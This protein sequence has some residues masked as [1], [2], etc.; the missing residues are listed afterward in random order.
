M[1]PEDVLNE[2]LFFNR[3][4]TSPAVS[5][6]PSSSSSASNSA[7]RP[8]T[9]SDCPLLISAGVTK[10][11]HLRAALQQQHPPPLTQQLRAVLLALPPAWQSVASSA[12]AS[13]AWVQ[14]Q[15]SSSQQLLL[16]QAQ[17][18]Q[19]HTVSPHHQLLQAPAEAVTPLSPAQVIS[20]DPSRPWRG[21][22]HQ[23][24]Q[25]TTPLY[26]QGVLWG[27]QHLSLGVWGWGSQ[28]A[29]QLI[30]KQA[31]QRLRLIQAFATKHPLAPKG[32]TCRPR[33]LPLAQSGQSPAQALQ[34]MEARWV[35]SMHANTAGTARLHSEQPDSQ[36]AWMTP[37]HAGRLHWSQ[38]QQQRDEQQQQQHQQQQHQQRPRLP[39]EQAA[40]SDTIDVL[41]ACGSHPQQSN[42]QRVWELSNAAYFDRQHRILWWRILHGSLMCGAYRAYIGRATP[43]QASCPFSCCS[44]QPQTISHLF[45]ECPVAA[46]LTGWLCRLWQAITGHLPAASIATL[47]AADTPAG[48][49]PSEAM[50]QTW[51]RLRLAVLHSIWAASQIARANLQAQLPSSPSTT[52][53]S[54]SPSSSSSSSSS[55]SPPSTSHHGQLACRLALKAVSSMIHHDWAKCNDNIRQ[56]AG[57][58][59]TWL[60][61]RDPNMTVGTF[62]SLWCHHDMMASVQEIDG[63]LDLRLRLSASCPISLY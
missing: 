53:S 32:L 60:R 39:S 6:A 13:P 4:I 3:Q 24:A 37:S 29:H 34:A 9:P 55:S 50:L 23:P 42:W 1:Q 8:L 17:T 33:L 63:Q 5:S 43:E 7:A 58:C 46:T 12:L 47:L 14:A 44:S 36:P 57:V 54:P 11:A 20:W 38:R 2:L 30:V 45:L 25:L 27:P 61:G 28:P 59:S 41:E 16:Q 22:D 35:A 26:L 52:S 19:L 21:P 62:E 10:V 15:S 18:G 48:H 56:V 49:A 31:S 40:A 51:H